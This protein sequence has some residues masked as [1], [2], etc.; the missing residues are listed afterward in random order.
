MDLIFDLVGQM[1]RYLGIVFLAI[2]VVCGRLFLDA[3]RNRGN[4]WRL[5]C[6]IYGTASFVSFVLVAFGTYNLQV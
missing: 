3:W 4:L 2:F 5:K 1:P 6:W